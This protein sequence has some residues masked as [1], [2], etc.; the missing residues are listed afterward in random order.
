MFTGR[1]WI[2]EVGLYDYR[3]R[4][5]SADLGRFIQSD[6]IRFVAGDVNIYR[7]CFNRPSNLT[8]PCRLDCVLK[9]KKILEKVQDLG[10]HE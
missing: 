4:V 7:Y 8:D 9:D 5:Y 1:E 10:E 6:P 3:N 2:A